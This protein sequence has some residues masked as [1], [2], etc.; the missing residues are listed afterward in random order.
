MPSADG[1]PAGENV[2]YRCIRLRKCLQKNYGPRCEVQSK[3]AQVLLD[4]NVVYPSSLL[5][6]ILCY[7]DVNLQGGVLAFLVLVLVIGVIICKLRKRK[8]PKLSVEEAD[9]LRRNKER[10]EQEMRERERYTRAD[11][12][13]VGVPRSSVVALCHMVCL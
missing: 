9:F 1:G 10:T 2:L 4:Y 6:V 5:S 8:P 12:F 7:S 11:L 3:K 13:Q